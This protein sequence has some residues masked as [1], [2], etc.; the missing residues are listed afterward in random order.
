[1]FT[2]KADW[3]FIIPAAIVWSS[4]LLLTTLD[5]ILLQERAYHLSSL[6]IAGIGL[7]AMGVTL[8]VLARKTL[9]R[10]FTH[11][12]RVLEEHEL[13]RHGIY[14]RVRHPAYTGA[15]LIYFGTPLTFNS[16]FGL[17]AMLPLVALI[18]YR[19]RIEEEMLIGEFGDEYREYQEKTWKLV[20]LLY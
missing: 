3:S 5:F 11:G 20:P 8:R 19:I 6:S 16:T 14:R 2:E 18:L 13:V 1:M 7:T 9:G 17:L 12:L 15:L 4:A 10:H